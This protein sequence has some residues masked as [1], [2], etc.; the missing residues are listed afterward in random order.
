MKIHPS[1][2]L[3]AVQE[4]DGEWFLTITPAWY[5]LQERCV[6][7]QH[8]EFTA[9]VPFESVMEG[10][11]GGSAFNMPPQDLYNEAIQHGLVWSR[12]LNDWLQNLDPSQKLFVPEGVGSHDSSAGTRILKEE[13]VIWAGTPSDAQKDGLTASSGKFATKDCKNIIKALVKSNPGC[14]TNMIA[15]SHNDLFETFAGDVQYWVRTSKVK[16]PNGF[17]RTFN[18]SV[19]SRAKLNAYVYTDKDD[20]VLI[21]VIF[22]AAPDLE[23]A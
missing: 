15:D 20:K 17:E 21:S 11:F 16:T 10:V 4:M 18:C 7:D 3:F 8:F 1:D 6:Y 22:R 14:V 5:W 12:D 9:K 23:V 19:I 2:C 13:N